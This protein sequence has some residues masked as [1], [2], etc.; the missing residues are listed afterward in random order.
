MPFK[1]LWAVLLVFALCCA[2]PAG[3]A[4]AAQ[5]SKPA[6]APAKDAK[7]KPSQA[8]PASGK[9]G[10]AKPA[11]APA[12]EKAPRKPVVTDVQVYS[13]QDYSRIVMVLSG[14]AQHRWQVLPQGDSP[15]R[16]LYV[17]LDGVVIR[18]GAP[19]RFDVKGDVARKVRLSYFKPDV[20][21]LVVEVENLKSQNVF[22][23][24]NPYRVV[25]DVQGEAAK[26]SAARPAPAPAPSPGKQAQAG[27]TASAAPAGK[28]APPAAEEKPGSPR[29]RLDTPA[30][31]KMAGQLAEQLGLT[32]R[33]VMV[34]AGHGGKDSG[35]RG[36]YGLWEKNVNLRVARLLG[37]HLE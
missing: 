23:L 5:D 36:A 21:R 25:I 14:Q 33:T 22:V 3:G 37:R 18:Q 24:E 27:K 11:P 26:K 34:D 8:K 29:V 35:A 6:P 1:A 16:L 20:A 9:A 32:V 31:R 7:A 12:P 15:L 10:P 13:G 4:Q 17:D 30:K 19:S 28:P 2:L